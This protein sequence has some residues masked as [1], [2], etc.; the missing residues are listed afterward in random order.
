MIIRTVE[1]SKINEKNSVKGPAVKEPSKSKQN[2]KG[3]KKG[4]LA[5]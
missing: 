1:N 3:K 5:E 4:L 2:K